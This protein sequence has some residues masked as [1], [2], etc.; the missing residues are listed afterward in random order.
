MIVCPLSLANGKLIVKL[1]VPVPP[2]LGQNFCSDSSK[3]PIGWSSRW[4]RVSYLCHLSS[5]IWTIYPSG[6]VTCSHGR[7]WVH[8]LLA[9]L[10]FHSICVIFHIYLYIHINCY[11]TGQHVIPVPLSI[12]CNHT[13]DESE[14]TFQ[15]SISWSIPDSQFLRNAIKRFLTFVKLVTE[16][17]E[18]I[19]DVKADINYAV[20]TNRPIICYAL[21]SPSQY[22][23]CIWAEYHSIAKL[24]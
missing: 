20:S 3:H 9:Q 18:A 8:T 15:F 19:V 7:K 1:H 17:N 11:Y 10:V 5:H 14:G 22:Q 21:L 13:W 6:N 2:P 23:M 24:L 16:G 4:M 12:K